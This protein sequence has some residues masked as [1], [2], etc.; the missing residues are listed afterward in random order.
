[1]RAPLPSSG[2]T[3]TCEPG[4]GV[5]SAVPIEKLAT[6]CG[7]EPSL[8]GSASPGEMRLNAEV[9]GH[10]GVGDL[11]SRV[12]ETV[13]GCCRVPGDSDDVGVVR[14]S[15]VELVAPSLLPVDGARDVTLGWLEVMVPTV[16]AAAPATKNTARRYEE[17]RETARR[18][19]SS[20]LLS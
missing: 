2:L 13:P 14:Q 15:L 6:K 20:L 5:S 18:F 9:V 1:M 17:R 19:I 7:F 16:S 8:D 11:K 3:T 4:W 10:Q 12:P